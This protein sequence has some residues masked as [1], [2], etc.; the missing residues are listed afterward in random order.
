MLYCNFEFRILLLDIDS[1]IEKYDIQGMYK[2]YDQWP[3]IAKN[4]YNSDLEPVDFKNIDHI[5]FAGMGGFWCN[6]RSICINFIK[7]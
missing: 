6:R 3:Q 4:A 7:N 5:V 1:Q 2:I